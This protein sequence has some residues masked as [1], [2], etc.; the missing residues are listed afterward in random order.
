MLQHC[1]NFSSYGKDSKAD[2]LRPDLISPLYMLKNVYADISSHSPDQPRYSGAVTADPVDPTGYAFC[3]KADANNLLIPGMNGA[4]YVLSGKQTTVGVASRI[5]LDYLPDS[6]DIWVFP[7]AFYDADMHPIIQTRLL[8]TG[9]VCIINAAGDI[10]ATSLAPVIP[11]GKFVHVETK[12][13]IDPVNGFV[14]VRVEGR[15]AVN[16]SNINTGNVNISQVYGGSVRNISFQKDYYMYHKDLI[17]W[18]G[19]GDYNNDYIGPCFVVPVAMDKVISNPWQVVGKEPDPIK[20]LNNS[21]P[22]ETTYLSGPVNVAPFTASLTA[23]SE[24]VVSVKGIKM[25]SYAGKSDSGEAYIRQGLISNPVSGTPQTVEGI[26]HPVS[27]APA[28]LTDVFE[29]NPVTGV[30]WTPE[31]V[32]RANLSIERVNA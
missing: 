18:D 5:Y 17:I 8:T 4:R 21:P 7:S 6:P 24:Y 3:A 26:S 1:D 31:E 9:Q 22:D 25:F 10:I 19:T 12:V 23:L 11:A 15:P 27:E 29:I 2:I 13:V 16:V 30:Q 20:F 32:H 14:E 28:F